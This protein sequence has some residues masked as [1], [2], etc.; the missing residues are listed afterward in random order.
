MCS[1]AWATEVRGG[2]RSQPDNFMGLSRK[3]ELQV[4]DC[5]VETP[6]DTSH[7]EQVNSHFEAPGSTQTLNLG[8]RHHVCH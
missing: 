1:L 8:T 3:L 6:I 7:R 2:L 5:L 4:A